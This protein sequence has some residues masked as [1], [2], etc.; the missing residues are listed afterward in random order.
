MKKLIDIICYLV[1]NMLTGLIQ[2]DTLSMVNNI[3][4]STEKN[5]SHIEITKRNL[6]LTTQF[7]RSLLPYSL[8]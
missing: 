1:L 3:H 5:I 7:G 4:S 6:I 8:Y 2:D